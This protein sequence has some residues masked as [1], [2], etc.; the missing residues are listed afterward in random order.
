M[1]NIIGDIITEM[2]IFSISLAIYINRMAK[3]VLL[4][5]RK[6]KKDVSQSGKRLLFVHEYYAMRMG[7]S[8]AKIFL[9][10]LLAH[11]RVQHGDQS[12]DYQ[13]G[14]EHE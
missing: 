1:I 5:S 6:A 14:P 11:Q 10:V 2:E 9:F 3:I 12:Q 13:A 4:F 7:E 8:Q